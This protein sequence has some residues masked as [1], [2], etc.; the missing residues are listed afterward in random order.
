MVGATTHL[1]S[2]LVGS[3]RAAWA[4]V[5][6]F[7]LHVFISRVLNAY[8]LFPPLDIP[9]H[10][11][12]G[13]AIA[14]FFANCLRALPA[15]AISSWLRP[16]LVAAM[17]FA[18]TATATVFWEFAEFFSDQLFG[19]HAQLGLGDTLLD[20]ALGVAGG[21]TYLAMAAKF[22]SLGNTATTLPDVSAQS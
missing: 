15:G 18:L 6:V 1:R 7:G 19:T 14:Y 21:L 16:W 13:V 11:F 5:L 9:M 8:L 2:A 20:M 22:H 10:F 12:G 17:V 4:P 3:I